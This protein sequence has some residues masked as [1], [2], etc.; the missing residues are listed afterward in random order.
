MNKY[1]N[2]F[3]FRIPPSTKTLTIPQRHPGLYT[4]TPMLGVRQI[5][6]ACRVQ[7]S[8]IK[9]PQYQ[10]PGR[11]AVPRVPEYRG[12]GTKINRPSSI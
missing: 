4:T 6:P 1:C 7:D 11:A 3:E 8:F 10:R 12:R 5:D 2:N 9:V